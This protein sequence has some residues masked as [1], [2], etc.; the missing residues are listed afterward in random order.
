MGSC[1]G[2]SA[3]FATEATQW[4]QTRPMRFA[5]DNLDADVSSS[6]RAARRAKNCRSV[7]G[8][9]EQARDRATSG[10]S[11]KRCCRSA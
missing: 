6:Y 5:A 2:V 9:H 8:S 1:G 4:R 7:S 3:R 11:W 10:E